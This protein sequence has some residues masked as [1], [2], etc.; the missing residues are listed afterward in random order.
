MQ[1]AYLH[2]YFVCAVVSFLNG[3]VMAVFSFKRLLTLIG[4]VCDISG[5]HLTNCE[6][7]NEANGHSSLNFLNEW[8]FVNFDKNDDVDDDETDHSKRNKVHLY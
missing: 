6:W 2:I 4:F 3:H 1:H 7:F 5:Y 8:I